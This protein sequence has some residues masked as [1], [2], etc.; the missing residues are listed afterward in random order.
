M[1]NKRNFYPEDFYLIIRSKIK[2]A[3]D[4]CNFSLAT[5][6]QF[7]KKDNIVFDLKNTNIATDYD[8]GFIKFYQH[9]VK[10]YRVSRH[11]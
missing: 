11:A 6:V 4:Y 3:R 10:W 2:D 5:G 9:K 7:N 8:F 1:N